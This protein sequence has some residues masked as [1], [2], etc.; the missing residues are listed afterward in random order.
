MEEEFFGTVVV[1]QYMMLRIWVML[2]IVD[3]ISVV[4]TCLKRNHPE[5]KFDRSRPCNSVVQ[6]LQY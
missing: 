4:I 2:G 1:L 5:P 3:L 6:N